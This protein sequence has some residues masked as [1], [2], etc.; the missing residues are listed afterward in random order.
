MKENID[1]GTDTTK[2]VTDATVDATF[3]ALNVYVGG[4]VTS[5]VSGAIAGGALGSVVPGPGT[6]AGAVIGA[7]LSLGAGAATS[8]VLDGTIN[9][10]GIKDS[11]KQAFDNFAD[12]DYNVE[13][14]QNMFN[15]TGNTYNPYQ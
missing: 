11:L 3:S 12:T 5:A 7:V 4:V 9:Y 14:Y 6:V 15:D 1:Q 10:Y 2:I 13:P 8:Y